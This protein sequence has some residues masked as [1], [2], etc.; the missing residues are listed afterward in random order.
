MR[1]ITRLLIAAIACTTITAQE[2]TLWDTVRNHDASAGPIDVGV[3][4]LYPGKNIDA[5]LSEADFVIDGTIVKATPGL[6]D[7]ERWIVTAYELK[8]R[9]F[10][11]VREPSQ[12]PRMD[13]RVTFEHVGG[14]LEML[15]VKVTMS[16]DLFRP[17]NVNER[18]VVFLKQKAESL[19][20]YVVGGPYGCFTL[21]GTRLAAM[22]PSI[23]GR[24]H[25]DLEGKDISRLA[26]R[27]QEAL[28][29]RTP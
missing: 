14:T 23:A 17:L 19:S 27:I 7:N 11:F 21:H 22:D 1:A 18:V 12:R 8:P 10:L 4:V 26:T 9:R 24:I 13:E 5:L 28:S 20:H 3:A 25:A 15:G 2:R 6:N 29:R 16:D